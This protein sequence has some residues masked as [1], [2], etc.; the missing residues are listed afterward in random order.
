MESIISALSVLLIF[1]VILY[2]FV[3]A[4]VKK[5]LNN[6]KP[7]EEEKISRKKYLK[8]LRL[9]LFKSLAI[10]I[11]FLL[12]IYVLLPS[13]VMIITQSTLDF[14]KFDPLNTIFIFI[15]LGLI[16]FFI[17]GIIRISQIIIK[18]FA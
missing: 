2:N 8:N 12:A 5:H 11:V 18:L 13:S 9:I 10:N 1:I 17:Y 7:R 15:E 4:D 16:G 3:E 14:W 6:E